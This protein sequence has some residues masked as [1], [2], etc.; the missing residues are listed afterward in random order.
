VAGLEPL[1]LGLWVKS[2]TTVLP[3]MNNFI[4][5][6]PFF[7]LSVLVAGLEPLIF[8]LRVKCSTTVLQRYSCVFFYFLSHHASG[9]IRS[10]DLRIRSRVLYH[11][12]IK[13]V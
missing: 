9:R 12:A 6:V 5:F 7:S 3:G 13:H 11:C 1:T 4:L 10:L 8:G 2:S